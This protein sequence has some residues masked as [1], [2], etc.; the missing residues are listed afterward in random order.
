M[1]TN[2]ATGKLWTQREIGTKLKNDWHI[3]PK[4]TCTTC[5]R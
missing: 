4:V 1:G 5:H 2:P 3:D